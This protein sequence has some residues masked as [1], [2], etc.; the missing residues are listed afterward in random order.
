MRNMLK[1]MQAHLEK[2]ED[3]VLVT[4]LAS[5]GSTP[6]GAGAHMLMGREGRIAGTIG[7]G[8]VEYR[9]EKMARDV[10][11]KKSS[12]AH[13]FVLNKEDVQDLGMICGGDVSVFF[14]Y[15]PP[16]DT[17][18]ISLT[19]QAER[20]FSQGENLW[21][22][23]D[24]AHGGRFS[25]YS[26]QLGI[27][28]NT[29]PEHLPTLLRRRPQRI[30][31]NGMDIYA[32]QIACEG[33]VYIF[34]CGH[35]GQELEPVLSHVGFRCI[36]LDDRP[37]FA[38]RQFFPTAEEVKCIDFHHIS[39]SVEIHPEDYVCVMTRGHAYDTIVQAQVIPCRPC[40]IGVIGSRTKSAQVRQTLKNDYGFSEEE[41]DRVTTPIGLS[42]RSETPAEIAISIAAQ[43]IQI[44]AERST[45]Q[46]I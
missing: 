31:E 39:D 7:G 17:S 30:R 19:R 44:R 15:L 8:A 26:K 13:D 38:N 3:L 18:A 11:E 33:R 9:A 16:A 2:G 22:L 14:S 1:Q 12:L 45:L 41:L 34:G 23:C 28:D 42:I 27:T 32:E 5:S 24:L 29:L 37:E 46:E 21:L 35:V 10:L 6:R 36:V 40:Y 4:V 20:S 43:M 25:L